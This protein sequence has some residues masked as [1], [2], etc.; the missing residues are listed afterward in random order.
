VNILGISAFVHD[1]AACLVV[2]GRIVANVEEERL[3]RVKHTRAFPE[4]AI[5]YVLDAGGIDL[6]RVDVIAFNWNPF[7]SLL[8]EITKAL[9]FPFQYA[10]IL[11]HNR[12]PKNFRS[13]AAS[14]R[15]RREI[16]KRYPGKFRGRIEWVEHH[17]AH[18]ASSYYLSGQCDAPATVLVADG[19][20][21]TCAT[22]LFEANGR[23]LRKLRSWPIL[24]SLG[25]L[26]TN[27]T[28]FLGFDD[29]QEGKTMALAAFGTKRLEALFERI[30]ALSPDGG[31]GITDKRYLGMWHYS[32]GSLAPEL[33][34]CRRPDEPLTQRHYDLARGMQERVGE[35]V[36]HLLRALPAQSP[37]NLCLAGGLFLN[38]DINQEIVREGRWRK[39]FIPPFASD[40]GGA[41][42][43]ALYAAC[44]NH[45]EAFPASF[46]PYLGPASKDDEIITALQEKRLPVNKISD[47]TGAAAH[48]LAHGQ[49]IGWFQGRIE[50]GPRALGNRSIL[51]NP[52]SS[53]I[54]EHLNSRVKQRESFRPFAP[55]ATPEAALRCFELEKDIPEPARFMLMTVRVRPEYR[56]LLAGITH[57]DG[58]ARLQVVDEN[59]NAL[60]FK[61]LQ[62]FGQSSGFEVLLN[63]SF[64]CHEPIVCRPAEAIDCFIKAHLDALYMESFELAARN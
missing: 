48:R 61:L 22:S 40:S 44:V 19:H 52:A 42:G 51:A 35:A 23:T 28:R 15:L 5:G 18:A 2:D 63:T 20:G 43:A 21:D 32:E 10:K 57:V 27:F 9:A 49:C 59:S 31:Y 29:H 25:I 12:P 26:Y 4:Q 7:R 64:N 8:A 47:P 41:A 50:S 17:D 56:R 13:I 1:S 36:R 45:Q 62:K 6:S 11:R 33:G 16:E 55:V 37:E 54:Q 3:D 53:G 14:F 34:P 60:L 58:T 46:S 39:V 38:C 24:D 30:I